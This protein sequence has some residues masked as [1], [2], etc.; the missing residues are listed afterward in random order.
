VTGSYECVQCGGV[1]AEG[2]TDEEAAAL[3]E[4]AE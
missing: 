1:F 4:A 2:W 3:A